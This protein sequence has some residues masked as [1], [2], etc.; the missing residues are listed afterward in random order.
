MHSKQDPIFKGETPA[1]QRTVKLRMTR[2]GNS[3]LE[4]RMYLTNHMQS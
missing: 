2:T 4:T 1:V 3:L